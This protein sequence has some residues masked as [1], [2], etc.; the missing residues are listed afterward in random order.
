L[1][2][3]EHALRIVQTIIAE[4]FRPTYRLAQSFERLENPLALGESADPKCHRLIRIEIP[5]QL[6]VAEHASHLRGYQDQGAA[7]M[8]RRAFAEFA[9]S[10]AMTVPGLSPAAKFVF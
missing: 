3:Q 10:G 4:W 9:L 8:V 5:G 7:L 6:N 2:A 1:R